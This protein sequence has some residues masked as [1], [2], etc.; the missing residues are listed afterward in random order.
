MSLLGGIVNLAFKGIGTAIGALSQA[1][2]EA[3]ARQRN[4]T[5]ASNQD[6]IRAGMRDSSPLNRAA[7][8]FEMRKRAEEGR[9]TRSDLDAYADTRKN[10]NRK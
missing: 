7:A 8:G 9:F 5:G 2:M 4:Y 10:R 3:S 1:S 6:L